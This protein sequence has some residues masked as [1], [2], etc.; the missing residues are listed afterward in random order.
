KGVR[1]DYAEAVKWYHKAAELQHAE[2][3]FSLGWM[4]ANG[5]GVAKDDKEAVKWYRQA[6]DKGHSAAMYNLARKYENGE[7]V[8]QDRAEALRW[9]RNAA[10]L[11][12]GDAS[13]AV[14]RLEPKK[15]DAAQ[16]A[17]W[18]ARGDNYYYGK[19]VKQDYTE[20]VKWYRRAAEQGHATAMSDLGV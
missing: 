18:Y 1:L 19:G 4:Y 20:A 7:G 9:Y 13:K 5:R 16:V 6:A 17:R 10:A 3:M 2:A 15:V 14:E 12:D 8:E 11:G